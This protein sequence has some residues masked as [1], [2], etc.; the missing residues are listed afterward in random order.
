MSSGRIALRVF[1]AGAVL[2]A[3]LIRRAE[4]GNPSLMRAILTLD[5]LATWVANGT[6]GQAFQLILLM[7][8]GLECVAVFYL[9]RWLLSKRRTTVS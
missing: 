7:V 5:P 9:V 3:I 8:F 4:S 6:P 2:K 1:L